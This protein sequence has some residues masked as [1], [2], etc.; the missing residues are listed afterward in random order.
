MAKRAIEQNDNGR[1]GPPARATD[2][3]GDP[4]ENAP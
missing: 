1:H 3:D 2:G 4:L